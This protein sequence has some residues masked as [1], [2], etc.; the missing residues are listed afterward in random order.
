MEEKLDEAAFHF[1]RH[2]EE[3]GGVN[4]QLALPL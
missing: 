1:H 4:E 2:M 3:T